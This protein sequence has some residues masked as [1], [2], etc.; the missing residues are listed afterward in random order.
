MLTMFLSAILPMHNAT[1]AQAAAKLK[2]SEKTLILSPGDTDIL[3]VKGTKNKVTWTSSD[4]TIVSVSNKGIVVAIKEGKAVITAQVSNKKLTCIIV[5]MRPENPYVGTAPFAAQEKSFGKI[6]AVIPKDWTCTLD[7]SSDAEEIKTSIYP[8][9]T[10]TSNDYSDLYIDIENDGTP[11]DA[12]S[13]IK[14]YNTKY[15]TVDN[16][17]KSYTEDN[18]DI[19]TLTQPVIS[20]VVTTLGTACKIEFSV[21]YKNA[22]DEYT[23]KYIKYILEFDTYYVYMSAYD[24]GDNVTPD[25]TKVAEYFLNSIQV[26]K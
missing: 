14:D 4:S 22:T 7:G 2:L 20:D 18:Y 17:K 19:V 25:F 3:Q 24:L 15:Y 1:T 11:A 5:V 13:T 23:V 10:N 12:Y 9:T 8:S 6:S 16:L 26:N 21:T